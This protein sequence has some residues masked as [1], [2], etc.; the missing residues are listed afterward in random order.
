M[1]ESQVDG[2][3]T[4]MLGEVLLTSSAFHVLIR[5]RCKALEETLQYVRTTGDTTPSIPQAVQQFV[6]SRTSA[7]VDTY[8]AEA[9]DDNMAQASAVRQMLGAFFPPT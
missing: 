4:G 2:L 1:G 6:A 3:I 7:W 9:A 5:A 8:L